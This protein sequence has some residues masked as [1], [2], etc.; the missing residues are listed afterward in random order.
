VSARVLVALRV[1]ASPA[2]AFEAFTAE[3]AQWWRPHEMFHFTPRSPGVPSFEPFEGGRFLETLSDGKVFEAGR[4]QAWAPG[5][6][7]V[8]TWR[9]AWF[10]PDAATTVEVTFT[11][12]GDETRVSVEHVGWETIPM[13]NKARHGFPLPFFLRH[14][15]EWWQA[16]LAGLGRHIAPSPN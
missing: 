3:I 1:K 7:L 15:G 5:E 2:R 11:P 9:C 8:F 16:L 10:E 14:E 4:I 6:R 13:E 12:V